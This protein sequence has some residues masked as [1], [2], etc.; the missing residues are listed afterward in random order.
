[1]TFLNSDL[2]FKGQCVLRCLTKHGGTTI[3]ALRHRSFLTCNVLEIITSVIMAIIS[4]DTSYF[5][6]LGD[7]TYLISNVSK[8]QK[9]N[10][11]YLSLT[12]LTDLNL[13]D[14]QA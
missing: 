8:F 14:F 2:L 10:I 7:G 1:M 9:P 6:K 12:A 13:S 4:Y 3:I 5:H 11:S